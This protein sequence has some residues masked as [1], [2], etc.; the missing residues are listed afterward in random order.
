MSNTIKFSIIVPIYNVEKYLNQCIDSVLGQ[1][2]KNFELILVNDGSP[3]GSPKICDAYEQADKRVKVIHKENGGSSSARNAGIMVASGEYVI[4]LDSDDYW[5]DVDALLGINK[6]IQKTSADVVLWGFKYY[7]EKQRKFGYST[8]FPKISNTLSEVEKLVLFI[9]C[10]VYEN[11]A[12]QKV[13]KLGLLL[14]NA[15]FFEEGDLGEDAEWSA[16]LAVC[17]KSFELYESTFYVYINRSGSI[18]KQRNEKL[19]IDLIKHFVSCYKLA[20]EID[21]IN[22]RN[23]LMGFA[24]IQFSY[25]LVLAAK[26]KN[27]NS[28]YKYLK[29]Y[30]DVLDY[31]LTNKDIIINRLRKIIGLRLTMYLLGIG[32]RI[33]SIGK[34]Q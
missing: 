21:D 19:V 1:T 9:K 29:Q 27:P 17:A 24:A 23:A 15:L 16:R 12:C 13:L 31:A 34:K 6:I 30:S 10:R 2:Y 4:F 7:Y 28:H 26:S 20:S 32:K 18:T 11:S 33:I 14:D 22:L 5:D 25:T 8:S 3:D